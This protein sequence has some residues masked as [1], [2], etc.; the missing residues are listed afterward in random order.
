MILLEKNPG[1]VQKQTNVQVEEENEYLLTRAIKKARIQCSNIPEPDQD[2]QTFEETKSGI[3]EA[4][5]S[6]SSASS[7]SNIAE[8]NGLIYIAGYFESIPILENTHMKFSI[9]HLVV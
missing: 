5:C 3:S 4:R 8:K 1:L 6:S 9:C 7:G 2:T